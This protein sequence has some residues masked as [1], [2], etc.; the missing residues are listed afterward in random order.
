MSQMVHATFEDGV[1]KPHDDLVLDSGTTVR[2]VILS[3]QE[4]AKGSKEAFVEMERFRIEHPIH[5]GGT[6][7]T[8]DQLHERC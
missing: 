3:P 6:R 8:R 7:L 5:S 4:T 2:I 1:L